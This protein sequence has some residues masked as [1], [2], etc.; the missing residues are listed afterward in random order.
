VKTLN[1]FSCAERLHACVAFGATIL[2]GLPALA[3]SLVLRPS[4]ENSFIKSY[5]DVAEVAQ[6]LYARAYVG[7][8]D[9][10]T[11]QSSATQVH[12]ALDGIPDGASITEIRMH[13]V[14]DSERAATLK[15]MIALPAQQ[16]PGDALSFASSNGTGSW[17]SGPVNITV[18][19]DAFTYTLWLVLPELPDSESLG[20]LM[21]YSIVVTYAP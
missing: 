2:V 10:S 8:N 11:D 13:G 19:H 4:T 16:S 21:I 1:R 3:D 6:M 12:F 17:S 20:D 5:G 15:L 7:A 9:T 14:D 18:D